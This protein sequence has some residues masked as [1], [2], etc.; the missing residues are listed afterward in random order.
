MLL[1]R[2]ASSSA[3]TSLLPNPWRIVARADYQRTI[4]R[5]ADRLSV[6]LT[7]DEQSQLLT[8]IDEIEK[9]VTVSEAELALVAALSQGYDPTPSQQAADETTALVEYFHYRHQLLQGSLSAQDV[10]NLLGT[11]RQTP[12]DRLR[13]GTLL[14]IK[15][16][17][18]WRFP[19]WQFDPD[20]PD[21]VLRGLPDVLRALRRIS[22]LSQAS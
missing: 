21:G 3:S 20:G 22:P 6:L 15:D 19:R 14:A 10:A 18:A 12:H 13:R 9:P 2:K 5:V 8:R 16:R 4:D 1:L 17:G 11:T 7:P